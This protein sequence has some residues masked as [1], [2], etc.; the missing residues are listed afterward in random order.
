MIKGKE[1]P[2]VCVIG[3]GRWGKNLIRN[4]YKTGA[5]KAV[6][7]SDEKKI[8]EIAKNYPGINL[9]ND[10]RSMLT[11][12]EIK[13]VVIATPAESHYPL[14]YEALL[15]DKHCFVEKPLSLD[16]EQAKT[17]TRLAKEKKRVLMVGHI[18][19]YHPAI[20]KLKE[21]I[22]NGE[23]GKI[24][25]IY[26]NRLNLGTVRTEE[27]ILWSFAPHD[28]SVIL[29]L[30]GEIPTHVTAVGGNYLDHHIADVTIST[31]SFKNGT[32]AHIFVSWLHPYKEQKLVVIG[33]R[34]MAVFDDV[35]PDKKLKIY[36]CK[37]DWIGRL[38]TPSRKEEIVVEIDKVE[39][40]WA[41][42]VHFLECIK[43]GKTPK[44]DGEDGV[45][46]LSILNACQTSLEKD[47]I[48]VEVKSEKEKYFVH[49]TSI[50]EERVKIG[51]G[52]KIWHF[53]HILPGSTIGENCNI[54]QNVVIGPNVIIGNRVKIQNNVSVYEGV[55]LEDEVFLGPSMV[56]TNVINPRS[57]IPRK[58]EIRETL[59]KKG[60]TI[61]ANST[62]VC[63]HTIG[64]YAF[65]AAGAVVTK[66][67]ADFALVMGN[68]AKQK[69]WMCACG[70]K[71]N[72]KGNRAKCSC[73][74]EYIKDDNIVKLVS[75]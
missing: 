34:K 1:Y 61:G 23:L 25:Y 74:K 57:A 37:I 63:G 50:V 12:N 9:F 26:S 64:S 69:G 7:D 2:K 59:V 30:L 15:A 53:S 38:P 13:G 4:F 67:V 51:N 14:A 36:D 5:L 35:S 21:I 22:Y 47:G 56:F 24:N 41:E 62:I 20:I 70:I 28:I 33:D 10:F 40:L 32:K 43:E 66:D 8:Q 39:P 71:L 42:V 29:D 45:Q 55:T 19:E 49:P 60:A 27:N 17:L 58:S 73:G 68:P 46:V 31:L 44:T 72:F 6:C 48:P 75:G 65:I 11:D 54:G 18:L 16:L 52:T 3:A